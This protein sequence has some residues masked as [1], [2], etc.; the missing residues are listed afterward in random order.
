[1]EPLAPARSARSRAAGAS[2]RHHEQVREQ[3]AHSAHQ[4][5]Q[6]HQR[7]RRVWRWIGIFVALELVGMLVFFV[8]PLLQE[9]PQILGALKL[10]TG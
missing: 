2:R 6:G 8:G 5:S 3:L 1:M 7:T 9:L 10:L 4:A